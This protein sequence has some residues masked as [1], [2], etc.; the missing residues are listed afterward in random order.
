VGALV[1]VVEAN[2]AMVVAARAEREERE[3]NRMLIE[4]QQAEFNAALAADQARELREEEE[5]RRTEAEARRREEE[6]QLAAEALERE[7]AEEQARIS[8]RRSKAEALPPEP[9]LG[10]DVSRLAVRLPDGRRLDRRWA[11]DSP[12]QLVVDWVEAAAA[13][14]YDVALVSHYPR[15]EFS[16]AELPKT[17]DELGLHPQAMLFVKERDSTNGSEE[18][19]NG[20]VRDVDSIHKRVRAGGEAGGAAVQ[21]DED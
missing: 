16:A 4:E 8:A 20:S 11:K 2:E 15:R 18:G 5:R 12:L 14:E 19:D 7:V 3:Q 17:L 9:E 21:S 6:E 10:P 1:A 13:D